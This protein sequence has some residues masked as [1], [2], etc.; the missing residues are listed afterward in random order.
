MQ[1]INKVFDVTKCWNSCDFYGT[2]ENCMV[3]NHPF[4]DNKG[5]YAGCII[6]HENSRDDKIPEKCPLRQES[7][8]I[9]K[10]YRM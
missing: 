4:F 10:F 5:S 2:V 6:T 7:I 8:K 1:V 3:C 9:T